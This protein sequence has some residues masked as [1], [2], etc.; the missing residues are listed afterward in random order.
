VYSGQR[1]A[2]RLSGTHG[3]RR[4]RTA[5][6]PWRAPGCVPRAHLNTL[7][8]RQ[9]HIACAPEALLG[10]IVSI[11]TNPVNLLTY[12]TFIPSSVLISTVYGPMWV[13]GRR[14]GRSH[15]EQL[16][17]RT[18]PSTSRIAPAKE[19]GFW[20]RSAAQRRL[21]KRFWSCTLGGR[22]STPSR[23][24][25]WSNIRMSARIFCSASLRT[26]FCHTAQPREG[27]L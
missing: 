22:E 20:R 12:M 17:M 2:A 11:Y 27:Q 19:A 16:R 15:T 8:S 9:H 23:Y 13:G 5:A 10:V 21:K 4:G 14:C 26:A 1:L 18:R 6:W 7:P 3:E 25:C 24:V